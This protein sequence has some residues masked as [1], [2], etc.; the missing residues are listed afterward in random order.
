M[1]ESI[2]DATA[3][4]PKDAGS[5]A[6]DVQAATKRGRGGPETWD[7]PYCGEMDMRI[8]RDGTW[9]YLGTPI[10]RLPLVKLFS[11]VLRLEY[12]GY[13]YLVTP[14]EKIRIKVDDAPFVAVEVEADDSEEETLRFRTN[15]DEWLVAGPDHPIRVSTDPATHEPAPYIMVRRGL[16]AKIARSVFYHLVAMAQPATI[17][18]VEELV[19]RSGQMR[20]SLGRLEP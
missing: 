17:D 19:V 9:Y 1:S 12:D 13:Y 20:F 3:E 18:G 16:E 5:L 2:K 8:A 15:V 11:T 10:G 6:A 14:V 4:R 7:P